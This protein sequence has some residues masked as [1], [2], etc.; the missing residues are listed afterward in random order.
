MQDK[1]KYIESKQAFE[2]QADKVDEFMLWKYKQR[3]YTA[4]LLVECKWKKKKVPVT[5]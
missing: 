2:S 1:E 3:R 5:R 4:E